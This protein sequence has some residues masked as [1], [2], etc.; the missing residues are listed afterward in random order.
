MLAKRWTI[1]L[2]LVAVAL[3][4]GLAVQA[5]AAP[6]GPYVLKLPDL[7]IKEVTVERT[8]GGEFPT[9]EFTI[10]IKNKGTGNA[11]GTTLAALSLVDVTSGPAGIGVFATVPVPE[12]P[13][14]A[15]V[16]VK[17]QRQMPIDKAYW[18]FVADAPVAGKPLGRLTEAGGATRGKCNNSFVVAYS[19]AY[20]NPQTFTNPAAL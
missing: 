8:G 5:L 17:F 12:I 19:S 2:V 9:H 20:G 10:K 4:V 18:V 11:A 7:V 3:A 15:Q 13:A 6:W 1:G 14:G 16:V